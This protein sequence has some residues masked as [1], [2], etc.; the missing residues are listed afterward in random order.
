M[1]VA[2]IKTHESMSGA[3]WYSCDGQHWYASPESARLAAET[4]DEAAAR[5]DDEMFGRQDA[6]LT[7]S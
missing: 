6:D 3:L 2:N 5:F 7:V 1:M 4:V